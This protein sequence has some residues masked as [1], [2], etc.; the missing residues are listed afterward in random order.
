MCFVWS[1]MGSAGVWVIFTE[2][3]LL[4]LSLTFI[5]L[6]A[7]TAYFGSGKSR[8]AGVSL[9]IIGII[10]P[11]ILYFAVWMNEAGHFTNNLLLPGLI[12][13]GGALVGLVV[14]FLVFLGVIMKT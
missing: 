6:G 8:V 4:V 14:G 9:L 2:I 11:L 1:T 5:G 10:I 13:V 7:L 3:L 12:Y